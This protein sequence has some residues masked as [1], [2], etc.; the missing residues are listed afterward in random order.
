MKGLHGI[1]PAIAILAILAAA[2]VGVGTPTALAE[3][4]HRNVTKFTPEDLPYGI[5]RAGE[6]IMGLYQADKGRW[7]GE[8]I[9][10]RE[11]E[12]TELQKKCPT[13]T[14]QIQ[15]LEQEQNRIREQERIRHET[16][17][18]AGAGSGT[19]GGTGTGSQGGTQQGGR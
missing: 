5:M 19:Q 3:M 15:E 13:C 14:Q 16:E 4:Q 6:N 9:R 17:T 8:L 7:N 18:R 12:R 2:G 10:V 11:M 1:I